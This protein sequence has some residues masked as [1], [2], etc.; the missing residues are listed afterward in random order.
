MSFRHV[1]TKHIEVNFH[2]VRYHKMKEELDVRYVFTRYQ[3]ANSLIKALPSNYFLIV[4]H[5]LL[6]LLNF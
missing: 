3:I 1:I 4:K 2:F 6:V 5:K